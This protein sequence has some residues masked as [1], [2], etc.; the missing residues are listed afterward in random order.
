VIVVL[1]ALLALAACGGKLPETRFY[2]LAPTTA[3]VAGGDAVIVLDLLSTD[4]AYDDE[5]IVYRTSPYR[6]DYYQYHRWSAPPG[7]LVGTYLEAA[8]GRSGRFKAVLRE[9]A[10]DGPVIL[11]GRVIAIEE[12]D[13]TKAQWDGRIVLAL[14]LLDGKTSELLWSA[15]FDETEPMAR[16]DPEAL[17]QALSVAL[18]RIVARATP[19][20]A[21]H[22]DRQSGGP[23]TAALPAAP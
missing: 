18:A 20:V 6:L 7:V 11:R 1:L 10:T 4:A 9:V 12:V 2:Q 16:Q 13:R 23:A 17:A 15:Q 22:A 14:T 19:I 8:L 5:R 3:R 21:D